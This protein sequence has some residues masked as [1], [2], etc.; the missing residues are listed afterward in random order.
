MPDRPCSAVLTESRA[1]GQANY[2]FIAAWPMSL[3]LMVMILK[4]TY[5][6][7]TSP[8]LMA[9]YLV[10]VSRLKPALTLLTIVFFCC[11]DYF[12]PNRR[13][14]RVRNMFWSGCL[15]LFVHSLNSHLSRYSGHCR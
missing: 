2:V 6:P 12:V 11:I 13:W 8:D 3:V 9:E 4:M 7:W 10:L 1:G 5:S 15:S 14:E